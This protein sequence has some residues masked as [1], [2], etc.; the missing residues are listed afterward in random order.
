MTANRYKRRPTYREKHAQ[1]TI[2]FGA[3][4]KKVRRTGKQKYGHATR[5]TDGEGL[6]WGER[7]VSV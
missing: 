4:R 6:G 2:L 3:K 1:S 5:Q 7:S